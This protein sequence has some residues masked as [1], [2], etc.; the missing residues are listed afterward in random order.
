MTTNRFALIMLCMIL[1]C[2][3]IPAWGFDNEDISMHGFV[4]Q[5]YMKSF[6]NNY[7]GT[8][9]DGSYEFNEIGINFS[10]PVTEELLFGIQLFSR[11]MGNFGDNEFKVDWASLSYYFRSW[12]GFRA[13]RIKLPFGFYNRKRDADM[14]RTAVILSQ[15]VYPEGIR[16]LT[17]GLYGG[18]FYGIFNLGPAGYLDYE[19]FG[20]TFNISSSSAY[21]DEMFDK[22]SEIKPDFFKAFEAL[23]ANISD[24]TL[25]VYH[26]EGG[27]LIWNTPIDGFRIGGTFM[28]GKGAISMPITGTGATGNNTLSMKVKFKEMSTLSVE[29]D[30]GSLTL[31]AEYMKM[32]ISV[33][34]AGTEIMG[35]YG[36]ASWE[37]TD[38]LSI[39]ATYGEYYPDSNDKKGNAFKAVGYPDYYAWQKEITVSTRFNLS[40][41]W[42]VKLETHFINGLGSVAIDLNDKNASKEDWVFYTLKT[43]LSF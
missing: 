41:Y 5:G 37:I 13:G 23:G 4:S 34:A 11:D 15:S 33:P 10:I 28:G 29:Y 36:G 2:S 18:S 24:I 39:G 6:D 30:F 26:I 3:V 20:G 38:F 9:K 17:V 7:F 22:F 14:L 32:D 40:E 35:W 43:S 31:V 42:C 12:L 25:D 21:I 8:T 1:Y 19:M 16:D 27:M